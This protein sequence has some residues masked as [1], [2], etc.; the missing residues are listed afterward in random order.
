MVS[1]APVPLIPEDPP[2]PS[3]PLPILLVDDH[4]IFRHGL[5]LGLETD[6]SFRVAAECG[7]SREALTVARKQSFSMAIVD[8]CLPGGM[9]GLELTK[10]LHCEAPQLLILMLSVHDETLYAFRAISAGARGYLMKQSPLPE[11]QGA[12][13]RM[14]RGEVALSH[15]ITQSLAQRALGLRSSSP[16]HPLQQ[17]SDRELEVLSHIGEGLSSEAI[18][19]T[20]SLSPKTIETHRANL[21]RKLALKTGPDLLRYAVACRFRA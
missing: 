9:D 5:R 20:L 12:L 17:L 15:R 8:L 1:S 21:R 11:I 6:T 7:S 19:R 4:P 14:R 16:E 13:H 10:C 3:Q 18:A 2:A